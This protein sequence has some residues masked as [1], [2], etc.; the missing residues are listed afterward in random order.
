MIQSRGV[1]NVARSEATAGWPPLPPPLAVSPSPPPSHPP[2]LLSA[3]TLPPAGA[4][5]R[6]EQSCGAQPSAPPS[7]RRSASGASFGASSLSASSAVISAQNRRAGVADFGISLMATRCPLTRCVPIRTSPKLPWPSSSPTVYSSCSRRK[8]SCSCA[9]APRRSCKPQCRVG[10][11]LSVA[12]ADGNDRCG[13]HSPTA[14]CAALPSS[15]TSASAV[16]AAPAPSQNAGSKADAEQFAT[17]GERTCHAPSA[18]RGMERDMRD[19]AVS[20]LQFA[21]VLRRGLAAHALCCAVVLCGW[22]Q[23]IT[24]LHER[25][26]YAYS[27]YSECQYMKPLYDCQFMKSSA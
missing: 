18:V 1:S 17:A 27:R 7:P 10:L 21:G 12:A 6:G 22:L 20:M 15:A 25:P 8:R 13:S 19:A 26:T 23:C 24:S 3:L 14:P 2:D 9:T 4:R 11:A 16:A 5:S